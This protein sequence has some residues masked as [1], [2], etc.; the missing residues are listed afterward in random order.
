MK[1]N[2]NFNKRLIIFTKKMC[3]DLLNIF[4]TFNSTHKHKISTQSD[5]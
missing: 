2:K 1:K 3:V 4:Y 5:K